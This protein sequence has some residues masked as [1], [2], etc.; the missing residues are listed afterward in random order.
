MVDNSPRRV[1]SAQALMEDHAQLRIREQQK[2]KELIADTAAANAPMVEE[3]KALVR[4][5]Q[6]QN[7][8]L[9]SQVEAAEL[10][11]NEAE[12]SARKA[13]TLSWISFIVSTLLA[14]AAL[15]VAIIK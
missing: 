4:E 9:Q 3:L 6:E 10:S 5:I 12:K 15:V 7:D 13:R 1:N 8:L 14:I 11:A 2:R